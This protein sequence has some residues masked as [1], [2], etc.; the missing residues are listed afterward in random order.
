MKR[1]DKFGQLSMVNIIFFVIT[2]FVLALC[3]GIISSFLA[4]AVID[5]NYT[6]ITA[7]IISA[8]VP[9]MWLGLLV[10]LFMFIAPVR[11]GQF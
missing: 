6:G 2:A 10:T 9:M 5:Y 7:L 1:F 8:I 3:S 11:P 4:Q